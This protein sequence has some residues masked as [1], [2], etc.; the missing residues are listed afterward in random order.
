M[1]L[2]LTAALLVPDSTLLQRGWA[3]IW[4]RPFDSSIVTFTAAAAVARAAGDRASLASAY[5][6][7]G[8][9]YSRKGGVEPALAYLDTAIRVAPS[10]DRSVEAMARCTRATILSFGGRPG[11]AGDAATGLALAR[12][13]R[14]V[15][16]VGWCQFARGSVA[17]AESRDPAAVLALLDSALVSQQAAADTDWIGITHFTRGYL[18]QLIGELAGAKRALAEARRV[19]ATTGNVFTAA[20]VHRYLGDIHAATGD[21]VSADLEYRAAQDGFTLLGDAFG[22]RSI[23]RV[24]ASAAMAVGRLDAAEAALT[25]SRDAAAAAGMAEGV[26]SA[27]LELATLKWLRGDYEGSSAETERAAAYGL[28]T[29]HQGWVKQLVYN[30]GLYAL[31]LGEL[32][33]AERYLRDFLRESAP[34]MLASRYTA[35][36]RLAEVLVRKGQLV[37][38]IA[39]LT[40]AMD[41][42]DSLRAGLDDRALRL[43][44][45]QTRSSFDEPDLGLATIATALV[46]AGRIEE[47]FDLSERRRARML[48]DRLLRDRLVASAPGRPAAPPVRVGAAGIRAGLPERS[49]LVEYLAGHQGQPSLAFILTHAAISAEILPSFDSLS[50]DADRLTALLTA[51]ESADVPAR[52]LGSAL[53]DPVLRRLPPGTRVIQVVAD[54]FLHRV[55]LDAL[56]LQDGR[57]L[58]ERYAVSAVPSAT[59]A[60]ALGARPAGSH[61]GWVLA[62]GDPQFVAERERSGEVTE[63]VFREAFDSSGGLPRL[64]ASAGEARNAVRHGIGGELRLRDAASEAFLKQSPLG[65]FQVIHFATHALVDERSSARTALALAPGDGE[66]GFVGPAELAALGLGADLVVL[67]ACRTAGGAV[68]EGEGIQGLT[69]PLLEGG[70]RAVVATLW[71]VA[72]QRAAQLVAAFYD[73]L[74]KGLPVGEA[75][76]SAKLARRSAGAPASEWAAFAAI[77]DPLLSVPLRTPPSGQTL[78]YLVLGLVGAAAFLLLIRLLMAGKPG[79]AAK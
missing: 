40:A 10:T 14:Q 8:F 53:L 9:L 17:I 23:G 28:K 37:V 39:E 45:F 30:R 34:A 36:A 67:S 75:L 69:A 44:V 51:G 68:V 25:E 15:R 13:A 35:R 74:A 19:A 60:Q 76:R 38:G 55:P 26:Y 47:A 7:L 57:L 16:A 71:P 56:I 64:R 2:L 11:A 59:V 54:G 43:L 46:R 77:G 4:R 61:S 50:A 3:N 6:G 29:G 12:A 32:D 20:W 42:L 21:W 78:S 33:R 18:L 63:A 70:A 48:S 24:V 41:Q 72:D 73:A 22:L 66:D 31:R 58:I 79:S 52:R 5:T 27:M 49:A 65:R 1:L 62:F